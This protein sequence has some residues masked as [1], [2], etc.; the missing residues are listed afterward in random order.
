MTARNKL[1]S[2]GHHSMQ[3]AALI[4]S[5]L[6]HIE[7]GPARS[8]EASANTAKAKVMILRRW[9][10]RR[11]RRRPAT[12]HPAFDSIGI[13]A[14]STTSTIQTRVYE[15]ATDSIA[16]SNEMLRR[17]RSSPH[18]NLINNYLIYR[19]TANCGQP[20][21]SCVERPNRR[22]GEPGNRGK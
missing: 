20:R 1:H 8:E 7:P 11:W 4:K 19:R 15:K 16:G 10:R 22:I 14:A 12:G 6:Q 17:C 21:A 5:I 13:L 2:R 3:R 18:R 9:W